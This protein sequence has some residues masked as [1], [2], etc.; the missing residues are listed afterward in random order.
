MAGAGDLGTST[1]RWK[2]VHTQKANVNILTFE[3]NT[4][5][6]NVSDADLKFVSSGSGKVKI[7]DLSFKTNIVASETGDLVFKSKHKFG[8]FVTGHV[9]IHRRNSSQRPSNTWRYTI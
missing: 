2:E 1:A 5:S 3:N 9:K 7:D 4:I 8:I 6:T